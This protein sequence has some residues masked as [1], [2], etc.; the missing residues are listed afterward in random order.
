MLNLKNPVSSIMTTSL[1]TI[2]PDEKLK[3][4]KEIFEDHSIHHIPVVKDD[5]LVGILSK[6]DYLYF[7]KPIHPDSQEQ[8][9]NDIRLK[10]YNVSEV[11]TKRVISVAPA[12]SIQTVLEIFSENMFH[13]IP[14]VDHGK[15]VGI[16]TTHDII[17]T[18]LHPKKSIA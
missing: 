13:A 2:S 15:I 16:I 12:D 8:Y 5:E 1:Q 17:F 14:V 18:L 11:M 4:V 3:R 9:L 10:N 7:L 6:L